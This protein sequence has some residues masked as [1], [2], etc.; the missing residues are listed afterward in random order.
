MISQ[1][2]SIQDAY[3]IKSFKQSV[4]ACSEWLIDAFDEEPIEQLV[5]GR[6]KFVDALLQRLWSLHGLEQAKNVALCAV[7][8]YGRGHLQPHSDVDLLIVSKR[9]LPSA[10]QEQVSRF[11]TSLWDVGLDV[12]QSVRT[13]KETVKLAKGDITIATNLVESRFLAGCQDIFALLWKEVNGKNTWTSKEFFIAK[14]EEQQARHRRFNGTAYNLEPNVKENPGC[15]RD[16]Q[17]IGWVAKKHFKEYDGKA[18]VGH[19]Y[20]TEDEHQ[21]LITCRMHLW[22]VRFALHVVAGRSENRLLFDYQTDVAEKMGYGRDGKSSVE[23]MMR[24]FFRVVRQV[25]ELN[26]MLLQR[27][28]HDI[29]NQSHGSCELLNNNFALYDGMISPRREDVF[30]SPEDI[31]DFLLLI[32]DTPKVKGLDTDCIRQLR[33]ARRRFKKQY[34]ILRDGCRKRIMQLFRN[35]EFF[36]FGWDVMYQYGILQSYLPQWD[37]IVGLMQF[38][39]FHAYTV[40]EHTH[41]LVKNVNHYYSVDNTEFPRCGKIVKNLDKPELLYIAAIFHDIA[42]GRNG[43]HST[44]G[45]EDV[46][47]FCEL[48]M[49]SR[50]D[51]ELISWLVE[52]HLLMSVVAQRRDIY[53]PEVIND[54]ATKVRSHT[55]LNLLYALTLADI[56]ATNDNLWNDWKSSLLRELYMMTQKA[57]DNGL[58]CRLTLSERS[59]EHKT[60]ALQLL[61]LDNVDEQA[62]ERLWNRLDDDYFVRFKPAQIAWHS[63]EI[64]R[65][66]QQDL[67]SQEPAILVKSNTEIA[68]GGTE[69]LLYGTDRPALFAQV[70]SVLDSRNC[71]IHDAHITVTK[72]GFVFDSMLV[73]ESDGSRVEQG[74]RTDSIEQAILAQIAKPSKS[75]E[76]TRKLPRQMRK[77]EVP[78]KIRFY[79]RGDDATLIE[80]EALDA[81]GILAKVGHAFVDQ[82]VTLK[83]AKIATIGERAEDVFIV[84]SLMGKALTPDQQVALKKRILVKLDQLEDINI[85]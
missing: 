57:L 6:A 14:Y 51:A 64:L 49:P 22:R 5:T 18:L 3:D 8:G 20:F 55:H 61:K 27:F 74:S 31:F 7:G 50:Q 54:F 32:T 23:K 66:E 68:K 62:I 1:L 42:K 59:E 53:D 41:R 81:P 76:N 47:R 37:A 35:A 83:L 72:D 19:G 28:S 63:K 56:R 80:L 11:I 4:K 40:D 25:S 21:E 67:F 46:L 85:S 38:D 12:G 13:V 60:N 44:L 71:S 29:L 2:D 39:L 73:L 43:D 26:N 34:Y 78:T 24:E 30:A 77:L 45:A 79:N 69:I 15:L 70:A 75:H 48:H 9:K 10:V 36:N 84:S 17:N 16:I 65:A 33:N 82:E 52:N 58:Q